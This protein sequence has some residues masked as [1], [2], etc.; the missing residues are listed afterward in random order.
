MG[1]GSGS[2]RD[3]GDPGSTEGLPH[4]RRHEE[5]GHNQV[6]CGTR[7]TKRELEELATRRG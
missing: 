1:P 4:G 6:A 3:A 7:A 2:G 5:H